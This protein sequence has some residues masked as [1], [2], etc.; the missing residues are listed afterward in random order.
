MRSRWPTLDIRLVFAVRQPWADIYFDELEHL[1]F[2][3]DGFF[4]SDHGMYYSHEVKL[5][6]L[7]DAENKVVNPDDAC[8]E[9]L[10]LFKKEESSRTEGMDFEDSEEV[11]ASGIDRNG[12]NA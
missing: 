12:F 6:D 4:S 5:S 2:L 10:G 7:A 3:G 9:L 1:R 8:V 11:K